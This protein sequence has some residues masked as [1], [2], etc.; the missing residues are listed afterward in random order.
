MGSSAQGSGYAILRLLIRPFFFVFAV[1]FCSLALPFWKTGLSFYSLLLFSLLYAAIF[2]VPFLIDDLFLN[3]GK[4]EASSTVL[5][6][7]AWKLVCIPLVASLFVAVTAFTAKSADFCKSATQV[8]W[9]PIQSRLQQAL[10]SLFQRCLSACSP[11]LSILRSRRQNSF[12][13]KI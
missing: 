5:H 2:S 7:K 1:V 11:S 6:L 3:G 10:Y 12:T 9:R 8:Y 4:R 13:G